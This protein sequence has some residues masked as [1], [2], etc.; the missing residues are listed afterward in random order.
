MA[1]TAGQT[2]VVNGSETGLEFAPGGITS[3]TAFPSSPSTGDQIRFATTTA[4]TDVHLDISTFPINSYRWF[5]QTG[6]TGNGGFGTRYPV[7]GIILNA[8]P[9]T[10]DADNVDAF[11]RFFN[12]TLSGASSGN[13][14]GSP[15][16][17][18]ANDP[19]GK[20]TLGF[21]NGD[22][23]FTITV[24]A[25]GSVPDGAG[26]VNQ[27]V[28]ISAAVLPIGTVFTWNGNNWHIDACTTEY[29]VGRR[30]TGSTA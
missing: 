4:T 10:A 25:G 15:T 23:A 20:F 19:A 22:D 26:D 7:P 5:F 16:L 9:G 13:V 12:V 17:Y 1:G 30:A 18:L 6:T 8:T 14:I 29:F 21:Y 24:A 3:V 2:V 11:E 27:P 28:V